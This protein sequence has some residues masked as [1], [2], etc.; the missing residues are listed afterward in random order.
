MKRKQPTHVIYSSSSDLSD[1]NSD[2]SSSENE[3]EELEECSRRFPIF[4]V[5]NSRAQYESDPG[6]HADKKQKMSKKNEKLLEEVRALSVDSQKGMVERILNSGH[7]LEVKKNLINEYEEKQH[8]VSEKTKFNSY[9]ERVLALPVNNIKKVNPGSENV[10][11]FMVNLRKNLDEAIAG[12]QETKSEIIDYITSVVRNPEAN[13]NILALQSKPGC[14][15]CLGYNTPVMMFDGSIK[16]VQDIEVGNTIMGDDSTGRVVLALGSGTDTMYRITHQTSQRS[17]TVNSE[18]ILCLMNESGDV[19]EVEVKNFVNLPTNIQKTFMG[20]SNAIDFEHKELYDDPYAIAISDNYK[21]IPWFVKTNSFKTR[22]LYLKGLI[23]KFGKKMEDD[24]YEIL[25]DTEIL[26]DG[27]LHLVDSLGLLRT[28]DVYENHFRIVFREDFGTVCRE[29][30]VIERLPEAKYYGFEISG[31]KRFVLGNFI[32][33]HN[34]KFI[35]S[36]SKALDLPFFQISFGGMTDGSILNGHDST[37][38]GSKPGK[39]YDAV[40]KAK[41]NNGIIYLDEIDK[42]SSVDSTKGIELNGILTHL[43]DKEQNMEFYD[44][45]IGS[46]IPINLSKILFVCS[47]NNEFNIDPVVLNRLHVIKIKE[48]TLLEKVTI[49]KKFTIPETVK[50]LKLENFN[51]EISDAMIKYVILNKVISEPGMRNI[52][53][54]F[55]SLYGK[56]N[57]LIYLE[58]ASTEDRE[59]ITKDLPYENTFLTRDTDANIIVTM[60]LIDK[61]VTKS[62]SATDAM[63][64]MMYN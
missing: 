22:V 26:R 64:M 38:I 13:T 61:L 4:I 14:G 49:V 59:R 55:A 56:I 9:L 44:H 35:R 48:S 12:H 17:Y 2:D 8:S 62:T 28:D 27:I 20:Y 45:Y 3:E 6:Q 16:M 57:T 30:I 42:I 53:K 7:S 23:E 51:I 19:F 40:V 52:T 50:N 37:Y 46:M 34:T 43:L 29:D 18:H 24:L 15:K 32:V 33:T 39:I 21:F 63:A 10:S 54:A 31:N 58:S 1:T 25:V 60:E 41:Y 47:F 5:Q 11:K 36:L